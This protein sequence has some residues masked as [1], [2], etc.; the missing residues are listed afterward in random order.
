MRGWLLP[1]RRR[2]RRTGRNELEAP[3]GMGNGSRE[4]GVAGRLDLGHVHILSTAAF[5]YGED[6]EDE[7]DY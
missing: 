6:E 2:G 7:G 1:G 5:D 4:G 3:A